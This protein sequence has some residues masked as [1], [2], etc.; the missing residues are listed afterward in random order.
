M[1]SSADESPIYT[2]KDAI[3]LALRSGAVTGSGGLLI[4]AVQNTLQRQNVGALGVVSRFGGTTAMF[5]VVGVAYG[6]TS[7]AASN[8]RQKDDFWDQVYG[9]A[10]AGFLLGLRN[11]SMA[12]ALGTSLMFGSVMGVVAY[13]GGSIFG[14][15]ANEPQANN[16]EYKEELRRRSRRPINELVNEIG[17]GRGIYAPGYEERRRLRIKEAY[18]IDVAEQPYYRA[19]ASG[20]LASASYAGHRPHSGANLDLDHVMGAARPASALSHNEVISREPNAS[21]GADRD[22]VSLVRSTSQ[23]SDATH[24]LRPQRSGT[25][26][27]KASLKRTASLGK[28]PSRRSSFAGS[29][30]SMQQGEREKYDDRVDSNS[31]FFTPIPTAGSPTELLADRFQAWR[32][33]LKD[34]INYFRDLHKAAE[35]R[36]KSVQASTHAINSVAVPPQFLGRGGLGDA[37]DALQDYHKQALAEANKARD[38]EN[39]VILQLIG[40]RS[41]LQQKI[42]EIKSLSGDF[43]NSVDR[44]QENT[45]KVHRALQEALGLVDQDAG[46][47]SGKGD[48]FLIKLAVD[49]QIERQIEEENYLHR[50][51]LNLEASGR[52]LES[53]VVGEIQ[54][55]YNVLAGILNRDA[56]NSFEAAAKLR[57]GPLAM[58]KDFEWDYFTKTNKQMV[59]PDIGLRNAA[60]IVYPGQHHP[61]AIELRSGMLERKS[62]YLKNYTPGWYILSPTHLHEFKS[63]DRILHQSPVM[64]LYLPEQKLGSHSEPGSSSHKFML[65]GRQS[66]SMHR[67]HSWVF[68]AETHDTML[69]WYNDIKELTEKRGE[70]RN[71]FVRRSHARSLSGNSLK[72]PSINSS[73]GEMAEDE[74]DK[75]P[76]ASEQSVRGPGSV[77]DGIAIATGIGAAVTAKELA[78]DRSEAGWRPPPPRPQP[79]GRFPSDVNLTRGLHASISPSSGPVSDRDVVAAAASLPGSGLPFQNTPYPHTDLQNAAGAAPASYSAQHSAPPSHI[80]HTAAQVVQP[81]HAGSTYGDWMAPLDATAAGAADPPIAAADT[82]QHQIGAA[83]AAPATVPA[84]QDPD[85]SLSRQR[86]LTQST[87]GTT[88]FAPSTT[89]A[90]TINTNTTAP[91]EYS[92][93]PNVLE[94]ARL[95]KTG[96]NKSIST[97]SDLLI[98]GQ[99][100]DTAANEE[101]TV[102]PQPVS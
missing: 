16:V 70:A 98:P 92:A 44:E 79:G 102:T 65:K 85:R 57:E 18:G 3:A 47:T 53:I 9:G 14:A 20:A 39:E 93:S 69:A 43:K 71:E 28:V 51:Y 58:N 12:S 95:E 73:E 54:K 41:D 52:E 68:R 17:E 72:A 27:K 61:A 80:Q 11:R 45:K 60:H 62:K 21:L 40:L 48:P 55:A 91:T 7:A 5:A 82:S 10:T 35:V 75:A 46:A 36:C 50:A 74:A 81:H 84:I 33:V 101:A 30:R 32:K 13:T 15:R 19:A 63:A 26:K 96:T 4:S 88:Y 64:S 100:P 1:A 2:P 94:R 34:L 56:T 97:L 38:L 77:P 87:Q 6:F 67:G 99:F 25:L 22:R 59:D 8:L 66:G 90:A 49:R 29:V 37:L 89:G 78:D 42:K 24:A 76:F 23:L 31:A 86:G 83:E